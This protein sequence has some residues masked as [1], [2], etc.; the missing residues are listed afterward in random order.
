MRAPAAFKALALLASLW[1]SPL[2]AKKDGPAFHVNDFKHIPTSLS[3]FEDS[4]VILFH[5]VSEGNIYRTDDAGVSWNRVGDIAQGVA[6]RLVMHEYDRSRA[7]VMTDATSH[8]RTEDKGKTWQSFSTDAEVNIF[9]PEPLG[10]HAGDPDRMLFNGMRC[11]G[12]FCDDVTMYTTDGFKT[13]AKLLR[14]NTV[15]CWWARSS[16]IFTTGKDELDAK[17][18]LCVVRDSLSPFK[19]DQRLLISDN[20]FN[21]EKAGG[22]VKEFEPNLDMNRPVQGV[23]NLAVVKKFLLV[24]TSSPNTDE[25][26]L[27]VTDDTLNWHRAI[28]PADH[29]VDQEA[30]TVLESTNYSIQIDVMNTRPSNP[31]GVMFT[32]N[33]NGTYFTKNIDFT[34][35]NS[36]GHVDFEK[37]NGIQGIFLVNKVKN[38]DEVATDRHAKKKIITEITFDD[39]RT[40]EDVM[41]GKERVHLHSVTD[42]SNVG[43]VF[44]SPAP[45]LVMGIGNT[46][47]YLKSYEDG[48]LYIS[49]NAGVTWIEGPKGPHKYEFGDQGSILLAVKD[50]GTKGEGIGEITYSLNHGKDWKTAELPD[51]LKVRP[52]ILTTT[53]DSTSLKFLLIGQ[54]KD[55]WEI[56]AI[57]FEGLHEDTC[58]ESDM[59]DWFARVDDKGEPTCLMGHTQKYHRR[60]KDAECFVKHEFNEALAESTDC[61]CTDKD[62]EC[63]YNFR[64]EDGECK[65]VGP[66]IVPDDACKDAKPDDTFK[67]SSGWRLIPGNTCKRSQGAQKDDPV[68]RKCSDSA[69]PPTEKPSGKISH[70]N[71]PFKGEWTDFEKHYLESG[72][73][74][75][76]ETVIVRPLDRSKNKGGPIYITND[77]GKNWKEAE[78]FKDEEIW[79]IMPHQH[80]KEMVYFVTRSGMVYYTSDRGRTF[81]DFKAPYKPALEEQKAPL[82]FHPDKQDWLIWFGKKCED[83]GECYLVAS[84]STDRGDNWKTMARYVEK[85]EFTGSLAYKYRNQ[86]QVLCLG[87]ERENNSKDNPLQLVS[88]DDWFDTKEVRQKNVKDFA[89]MAE[90]IV[91]A[92]EDQ[93][94][95]T[96]QAH[97]SIDGEHYAAAHFPYNFNVGQQHAYTVLDSSTH[98]VNLFVVTETKEDF[99]YGTIIKSNSNGTSYVMSVPGVNCNNN[100]YVDYEKMLGLEGVSLV[101][102]VAN[103]DSKDNKKKLQSKISHNDGAEWSFLAPPGQDVEGKNYPCSGNGDEKCALHIHGYTEREDHRKTYSSAGAVGLMFGIGNVGDSLGDIKDADTFMTTDAGITWKNVKKGAWTWQF[104]DQGSIIVLAQRHTKTKTVSYTADEGQTWQDY[105]FTEDDVE[106]ADVT[107]LRSGA[108]RNFIIWGKKGSEL[109]SI[110]V[111][112]TGLTG[113]ACSLEGDSDYYTWSPKHP[114]MENDCLFGHVSQYRRKKTDRDCYNGFKIEHSYNVQNCS[115]T[116][117]DFE[118]DYNFEL[119]NHGACSLVKGLEPKSRE[120]WCKENP[121]VETYYA[122]S[123]Y[124]RIPLTTCTGGQEFDKQSEPQPCVGMEDEFRRVHRGP[125]GVAIFFAVVIPVGIAAAAGWWVYRNWHGKFGA[126][127]LGEGG[128]GGGFGGGAGL[129]SDAPWI[130]Y[131]VIALSAVV[132][133]VGAVPLVASAVWRAGTSAVQGLLGGGG[134]R[135]R[136][137]RLGGSGGGGGGGWGGSRRFTTRDSF[138][139]GRGDYAAV[140]DDDEGELLGDESDEEV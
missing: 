43:R 70:K 135:G 123:G 120:Q 31:M 29:R 93:E 106:I 9:Q 104:G 56:V 21:A 99:R 137:S 71:Y 54:S 82:A 103:R 111:D 46:G 74:N 76:D 107:T 44:S 140:A 61:E 75:N 126:I 20:Y 108:S 101:N 84:V 83:T 55:K 133:V 27:F 50:T 81:H 68:E 67:G 24:A 122:P 134:G 41:V 109:I 97:A 10:F 14:D 119:D 127:R 22:D 89:T 69:Q 33:S 4:D 53:Q 78:V 95:K 34:N 18:I 35:R 65:P 19:H 113:R 66:V 2:H 87:R 88:S 60:K 129:D 125:S 57:D 118:C 105:Q 121:G 38:G 131:P 94:K 100:Y 138:A 7:Y 3:Y 36:H 8:W 132:A 42:L 80:F 72:E 23:V 124:R 90:F 6:A 32:S 48:N 17:R 15:G 116:R 16:A 86:K 39:G 26:A 52:Y 49:D 47:E 77:Q 12:I 5:D 110:N 51:G 73:F 115:C 1:A 85:C 91:V 92:T 136:F 114:M 59:E 64:R 11:K 40:F 96:L 102:I 63:D 25:M 128:A 117:R 45:G 30:Y 130:K 28:F 79:A 62:F 112:F 13:D 58:K 37:I 139:R 98:A